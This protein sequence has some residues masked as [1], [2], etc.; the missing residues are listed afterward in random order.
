MYQSMDQSNIQHSFHFVFFFTLGL[1][2]ANQSFPSFLNSGG[3][4]WSLKSS[5]KL[6][7][8]QGC[9]EPPGPVVPYPGEV[10]CKSGNPDP[11]PE[12]T[13]AAVAFGT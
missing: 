2:I 9:E 1:K 7:V 5:G 8:V 10:P 4:L 3:I 13:A 6:E 12:A 11:I